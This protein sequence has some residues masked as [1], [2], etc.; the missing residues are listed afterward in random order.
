[1]RENFWMFNFRTSVTI[2]WV[3]ISRITLQSFHFINGHCNFHSQRDVYLRKNRHLSTLFWI[4]I[5]R[6]YLLKNPYPSPICQ[7]LFTP[8]VS[9]LF[10]DIENEFL[11]FVQA[12]KKL[13]SKNL[14][15]KNWSRVVPRKESLPSIQTHLSPSF[16][17]NLRD[18][19]ESQLFLSTILVHT[20]KFISPK[21]ALSN[22]SLFL[23]LAYE[24]I[25]N[26]IEYIQV[27]ESNASFSY[28]LNYWRHE[29][30]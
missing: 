19:R 20:I 18:P 9:L 15:H 17:S 8:F 21:I 13:E 2:K 25:T 26:K 4:L 14:Y 5:F 22:L 24:T 6:C 16:N 28:V 11:E 1:M 27:A 23:H 29:T 7:N 3:K 30:L 12:W 10:V